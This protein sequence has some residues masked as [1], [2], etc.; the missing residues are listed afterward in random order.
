M[1]DSFLTTSWAANSPLKRWFANFCKRCLKNSAAMSPAASPST[2]TSRCSASAPASPT[3]WTTPRPAATSAPSC[4]RAFEPDSALALTAAPPL[5]ATWAH[6]A[7]AGGAFSR[8]THNGA[9]KASRPRHQATLVNLKQ[10]FR[11]TRPRAK[12]VRLRRGRVSF[13]QILHETRTTG[14]NK[15]EPHT[16]T[17]ARFARFLLPSHPSYKR[18][19]FGGKKRLLRLFGTLVIL[20][21]QF[22]NTGTQE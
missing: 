21:A 13:V 14:G 7:T 12:S 1:P 2:L 8:S 10:R 9:F 19:P 18:H 17:F 4:S 16:G 3:L 11:A 15:I 5:T 6:P 20:A 22:R